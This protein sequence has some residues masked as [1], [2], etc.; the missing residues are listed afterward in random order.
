VKG[1]LFTPA[2][3]LAVCREVDPK[4]ETR[5]VIAPQ[6][7][8][9]ATQLVHFRGK[10]W[11]SKMFDPD[12]AGLTLH[13]GDHACDYV[14]GER[15]CLLTTWAVS[16]DCDHLK[17]TELPPAIER[18][19]AIWHAGLSTPKP[20]LAGELRSG[21]FLPNSLRHLMPVFEIVGVKAERVQDITDSAA[22]SEGVTIG[23]KRA[24]STYPPRRISD[25]PMIA[26]TPRE[27]FERLWDS[28]NA[29]RKDENGKRLPY[30]WAD[31]P[32]VW[33]VSFRRAAA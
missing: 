1:L 22:K 30:A 25:I 15:R 33:I 12:I 28:I 17:P 18:P 32:W 21:R 14:V 13:L 16:R 3:A 19:G 10:E 7:S 23:Q 20:K 27:A 24:P 6:P 11:Q 26:E 4:T 5:R 9:A 31:N 8:G 2:M 29:D